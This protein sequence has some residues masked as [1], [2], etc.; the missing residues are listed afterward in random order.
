[1]RGGEQLDDGIDDTFVSNVRREGSFGFIDF[2]NKPDQE[3]Q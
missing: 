2:H 1:V 3:D